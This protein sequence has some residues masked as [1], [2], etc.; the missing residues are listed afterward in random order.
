MRICTKISLSADEK[1][2]AQIGGESLIWIKTS[3]SLE[4]GDAVIEARNN[5]SSWFAVQDSLKAMPRE[6]AL[7]NV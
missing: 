3:L 1:V 2:Q 6:G 5:D 4:T 7:L